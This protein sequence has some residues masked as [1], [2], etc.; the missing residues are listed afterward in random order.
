[1]L[2]GGALI[3]ALAAAAAGAFGFRLSLLT[4]PFLL[5][6]GF[7]LPQECLSDCVALWWNR[8]SGLDPGRAFSAACGTKRET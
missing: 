2:I 5:L 1:M 3:R 8:D 4:T 6:A 7:S